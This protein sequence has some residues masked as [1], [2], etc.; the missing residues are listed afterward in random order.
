[1][2]LGFEVLEKDKS[3]VLLSLKQETEVCN[4]VF[5]V[6]GSGKSPVENSIS[7]ASF[8]RSDI[9]NGI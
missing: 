5:C 9:I 8:G 6:D 4:Q 3:T 1:M 2:I 7:V